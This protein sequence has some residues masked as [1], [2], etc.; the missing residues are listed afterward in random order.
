MPSNHG[1]RRDRLGTLLDGQVEV[2]G[3][4]HD[5]ADE[6]L[7]GKA[8]IALAVLRGAPLEVEELRALALERAQVLVRL[9]AGGVTL[10]FEGLDLG[11]QGRRRDVDLVSSFLGAVADAIR[12]RGDPPVRS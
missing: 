3:E 4:G 2:V 1:F 9:A 7:G 5:L 6:V 11:Q 8:E 10:G 12:H